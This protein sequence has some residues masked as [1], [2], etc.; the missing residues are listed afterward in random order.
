[1]NGQMARLVF[2][3]ILAATLVLTGCATMGGSNQDAFHAVVED[4]WEKYS[5]AINAG[6]A[7]AWITLWDENGVQMPPDTPWRI[8]KQAI[9]AANRPGFSDPIEDFII[10]LDETVAAGGYGYARGTYSFVIPAS[11]DSPRLQFEG[12]YLT[13]YKRQPDGSWKIYRDCFNFNG[14][15][16]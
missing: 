8:G 13:I 16:K 9:D 5:A 6:D 7:D 1:M 12:K 10:Y 15:P 3:V 14:P 11:A 4:T 2:G